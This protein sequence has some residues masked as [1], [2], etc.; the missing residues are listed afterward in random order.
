MPT[1]CVMQPYLYPYPLYY[2]MAASCDVFVMLD[3]VNYRTGSYINRNRI[4]SA[5]EPVWFRRQVV[6]AS[7]NRLI[8]QHHYL[9]YEDKI[10]VTLEHLYSRSRHLEEVTSL[11][12]SNATLVD[13]AVSVVNAHSVSSVLEWLGLKTEFVF[14]SDLDYDPQH[15]GLDRI[16]AICK[17]LDAH[18]YVNLPGGRSLYSRETFAR[19]GIELRFI[20]R[21]S[22]DE[23]S[24]PPDFDALSIIH[25]MMWLGRDDLRARLSA[26]CQM[27]PE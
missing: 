10:W 25:S 19:R 12:R 2:R 1:I 26:P 20:E 22:T 3:D 21:G 13:S 27:L 17:S 14:S 8:N 5:N 24:L 7:Q 6:A 15:R 11:L 4:G 18:C 16:L 23:G 9:D